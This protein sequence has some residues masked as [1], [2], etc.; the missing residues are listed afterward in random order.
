MPA[1]ILVCIAFPSLKLLYVM[2]DVVEPALTVKAVGTQW[3]WHYEYGVTII[4]EVG[5]GFSPIIEFDSFMIPTGELLLGE[6]RLLEVDNRLVV[7][8]LTHV[9]VLVTGAD[10]LHS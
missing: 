2:D 7:P 1:L 5:P 8:I 10:V 6:L 4:D 3:Y 9:R